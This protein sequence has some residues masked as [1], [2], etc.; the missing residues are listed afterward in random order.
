VKLLYLQG[1]LVERIDADSDSD[2]VRGRRAGITKDGAVNTARC[3]DGSQVTQCANPCRDY[4][5]HVWPGNSVTYSSFQLLGL[6]S[7]TSRVILPSSDCP[8]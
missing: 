8:Q 6:R 7:T 3:S 1:L 5:I 2:G 4:V